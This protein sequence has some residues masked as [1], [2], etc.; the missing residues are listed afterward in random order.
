MAIFNSYV[1]LPEGTGHTHDIRMTRHCSCG[2]QSWIN[3]FGPS[4]ESTSISSPIEL[5]PPRLQAHA[6]R[7]NAA[8]SIVLK[9]TTHWPWSC[10][11]G[12]Q[13][14]GPHLLAFRSPTQSQVSSDGIILGYVIQIW[15]GSTFIDH[16][17]PP[18]ITIT[19]FSSAD[20]TP[21]LN[22]ISRRQCFDLWSHW[23]NGILRT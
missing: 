21:V 6:P 7:L 20:V 3:A 18:I 17:W 10:S 11:L 13:V 14:C 22:Q 19:V 5:E 9:K 4:S 1:K 23:G 15:N 2:R 12:S 16:Y 8:L